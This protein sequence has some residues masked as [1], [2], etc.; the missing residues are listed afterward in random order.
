MESWQLPWGGG[1]DEAAVATPKQAKGAVPIGS[2][3]AAG[4]AAGLGS[5][6]YLVMG[7]LS[8]LCFSGVV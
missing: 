7:V 1:E 8:L 3:A 2:E 4:Q 5:F 6:H